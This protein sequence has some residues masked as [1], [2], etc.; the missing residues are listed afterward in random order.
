MQQTENVVLRLLGFNADLVILSE[1]YIQGA[2]LYYGVCVYV[3]VCVCVYVCIL[4]SHQFDHFCQQ[5]VHIN[6]KLSFVIY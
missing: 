2:D 1:V 3:Y 6:K 5:G 4:L